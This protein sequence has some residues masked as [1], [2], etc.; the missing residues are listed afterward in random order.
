MV[1]GLISVIIPVY[2]VEKYLDRCVESVVNQTYQNLE[3]ILV[4]DGSPDN[5]P[6]MCDLWAKKDSRIKVIHQDNAGASIARNA[7]L[8]YSC[9]DYIAFVDSDDYLDINFFTYLM[10]R[11][12]E[13][14]ADLVICKNYEVNEAGCI[15]KYLSEYDDVKN[16]DD[17]ILGILKN[18]YGH[19]VLWNKLYKR[20]L[21]QNIRFRCLRKYEDEDVLTNVYDGV[22]S[23]AVVDE[24]LYYYYQNSES[25]MHAA[26]STDDYEIYLDIMQ[27]RL[28]RYEDSPLYADFLKFYLQ[29][30]RALCLDLYGNPSFSIS[31]EKLF[32]A[33]RD[34]M[35]VWKKK[36]IKLFS[37]KETIRY[38]LFFSAPKLY[39]RFISLK[40]FIYKL[41][42]RKR[43]Q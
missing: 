31:Y 23:V 18:G 9:G 22:K 38:H 8:E 25:T 39:I 37:S 26:K 35:F 3:I 14:D 10:N 21:W 24:Y 42:A 15:T 40:V 11:E 27:H 7:G 16:G 6:Q 34:L 28:E 29:S 30:L 4:D 17:C 32:G 41:F 43:T 1:A 2:K 20:H 12:D 13:T 19:T 36:R 5:C 33:F